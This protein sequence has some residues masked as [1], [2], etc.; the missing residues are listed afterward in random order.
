MFNAHA[1][2][3]WA[4][5]L[6]DDPYPLYIHGY[7]CVT[8][9]CAWFAFFFLLSVLVGTL[10]KKKNHLK[11]LPLVVI[12]LTSAIRG[13]RTGSKGHQLFHSWNLPWLRVLADVIFEHGTLNSVGSECLFWEYFY[14]WNIKYLLTDWWPC[15]PVLYTSPDQLSLCFKKITFNLVMWS[16][17][18][19]RL[20]ADSVESVLIPKI[21]KWCLTLIILNLIFLAFCVTSDHYAQIITLL[22]SITLTWE[23][24]AVIPK[25]C[26]SIMS[27]GLTV[28]HTYTFQF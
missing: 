9:L 24:E 11:M 25:N 2:R 23:S 17:T 18:W 8:W 27:Q 15:D 12:M 13:G 1:V 19:P 3:E 26:I 6:T 21:L 22:C 20:T 4:W 28:I 5:Q 16:T 14:D 10:K 7:A